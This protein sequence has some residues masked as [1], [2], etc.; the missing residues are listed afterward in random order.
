MQAIGYIT[1]GPS[2]ILLDL[3]LL[4]IRYYGLFFALAF[5]LGFY[6]MQK[7]F[8]LEDK[9]QEVLDPL[10][11]YMVV[12]T[13]I[14]A[15]LGHCLFYEADYYLSNPIE[16]IK[17]W[18]G[19]LA[20]HGASIG[21]LTSIWFFVKKFKGFSYIWLLSRLS[22]VVALGGGFI[23]TGNFFNSEIFGTPSQFPW[24]VVFT[25]I[26][27]LPRH[28]TQLYEAISYFLIFSLL[29][30]AYFKSKGKIKPQKLLGAFFFLVFSA[31]FLLEYTK[32]PQAAFEM[33]L[34]LHM[35][36]LLSIPLVLLGL[37]LFTMFSDAP[38]R[39]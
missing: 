36:Q 26:D 14:G 27:F 29:S 37:Y 28:P 19:G 25:K 7:M 24:S 18:K 30:W 23:R 17:F 20:S 13:L 38:K 39:S 32:E 8:K 31:R 21:I 22:I 33:N 10:L 6:L 5:L 1:W 2:P 4:Q 16:I 12:G 3:G 35:G 9:P 11:T 34:P 15:R